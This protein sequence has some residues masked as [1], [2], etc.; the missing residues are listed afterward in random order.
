MGGGHD[1]R[2]ALQEKLSKAWRA[3]KGATAREAAFGSFKRSAAPSLDAVV[4]LGGL[5][6]E[7]ELAV[8]EQAVRLAQARRLEVC[9]KPEERQVGI[10]AIWDGTPCPQLAFVTRATQDPNEVF[11]RFRWIFHDAQRC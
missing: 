6:E 10:A 4:F 1:L 8:L 9:R 2:A 7:P 5:E 11:S 3:F